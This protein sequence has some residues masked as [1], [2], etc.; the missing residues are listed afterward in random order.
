[1]FKISATGGASR[2]CDGVQRREF[3]K[4]GGLAFGGLSLA[5]LLAARDAQGAA[6]SARTKSVIMVFLAGGPSHIDMYDLKPQAPI[7]IRGEFNPIA[8][9]VPGVRVCEH[10]PRQATI[11]DKWSVINGVKMIDT[12]SAWVVMTGFDEKMK[13]PVVGSVVSKVMGSS[14]NGVPTYVSLRGENGAD[15]GEPF[16]LGAAHRPFTPGEGALESMGRQREVT[17]ERFEDRKSLLTG[18]DRFRQQ[19]E[20][21]A[22]SLAGHSAYTA[23][24]LEML[25]SPRARQ[26]FD[27]KQESQATRDKYGKADRLL[28]A[29][30]LAEAGVPMIT[31]SLAG[32]VCPPGDWDTHAGGD[33]RNETNFDALRKKLPVYDMAIHALITD[34]HERGLQDDVLVVACGEFGRTPKINKM[35]GRDHWAP[36]GSVLFSGGGLRMGQTIGDTGPHAAAATNHEYSAQSVLAVIYRHLGISPSTKLPDFAGRPIYLLDDQRGIKELI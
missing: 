9:N 31:L 29:R 13:R 8:T 1:M 22:D 5:G 18:L 25:A 15:P 35:G 30:R 11:A 19:A 17:V 23:Q 32:T 6:S 20:R 26:A 27:L 33:Q 34:I 2:M 21:S 10:M 7:E 24:A 4:L 3:L 12:H 36:A 14:R 28:L 16:Y